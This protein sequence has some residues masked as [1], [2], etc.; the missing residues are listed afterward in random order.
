V[1]T[2]PATVGLV[3][4]V[5]STGRQQ[6][7]AFGIRGRESGSPLVFSEAFPAVI[8]A[9]A[10]PFLNDPY[11]FGTL[12]HAGLWDPS[13]V[14]R[15]LETRS[16]PFVVTV[17]D[18]RRGAGRADRSSLGGAGF[19]YFWYLDDVWRPT[20]AN[21]RMDVAPGFFVW[22]PSREASGGR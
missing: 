18:L 6:G 9:G 11:A 5:S 12:A 19:A 22:L 4:T 10:L 15:A 8:E 1:A 2:V 20:V 14:R 16:V 13:V 7:L 3:R 21:Y 17:F